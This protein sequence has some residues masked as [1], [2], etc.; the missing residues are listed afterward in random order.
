MTVR[1]AEAPPRPVARYRLDPK[2]GR[3]TSAERVARGKA[4]RTAVPRDSHGVFDPPPDRLSIPW[5]YLGALFATVAGSIIL[6]IHLV[7]R[8]MEVSPVAALR[9]DSG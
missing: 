4:A 9:E 1:T 2:A 7:G 6:A 3:L 5:L 8:W